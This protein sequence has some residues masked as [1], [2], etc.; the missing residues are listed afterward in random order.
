MR[1]P[2]SFVETSTWV[3][4]DKSFICLH[5]EGVYI[6]QLEVDTMRNGIHD[7]IRVPA[8]F[9]KDPDCDIQILNYDFSPLYGKEE[10]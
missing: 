8:A 7:Q 4:I 9:C 3:L 1:I 6:E 5:D 2:V 10:N